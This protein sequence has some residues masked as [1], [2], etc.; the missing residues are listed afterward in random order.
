[1]STDEFSLDEKAKFGKMYKAF[2]ESVLSTPGLFLNLDQ[3]D[4]TMLGRVNK[5]DR[6]V[7]ENNKLGI[8]SPYNGDDAIALS[9]AVLLFLKNTKKPILSDAVCLKLKS[10]NRKFIL[11]VELRNDLLISVHIFY[12]L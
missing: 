10:F 12:K 9:Y 6:E 4:D 1:M 3:M 2:T 11:L 7:L 5:I 8:T